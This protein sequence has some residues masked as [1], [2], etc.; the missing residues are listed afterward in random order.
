MKSAKL[1]TT[2]HVF[3][4]ESNET[5]P[6]SGVRDGSILTESDTGN[7]FRFFGGVWHLDRGAQLTG[8]QL[9]VAAAE[10]RLLLED[11]LLEIQAANKANG[12]EVV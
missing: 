8:G 5:K 9:Q 11:I 3:S 6:T 1:V 7:V 2:I 12:I 4:G 10:L